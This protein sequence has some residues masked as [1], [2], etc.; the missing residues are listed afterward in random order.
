M[1]T[2]AGW[3]TL[4]TGLDT[5]ARGV[6]RAAPAERP[7]LQQRRHDHLPGRAGRQQPGGDCRP[8]RSRTMGRATSTRS[9]PADQHCPAQPPTWPWADGTPIVSPCALADGHEPNNDAGSATPLTVVTTTVTTYARAVQQQRGPA[10]RLGLL[11]RSPWP[12]S[13]VLSVTLSELPAD[14]RG[15]RAQRRR[16]STWPSATTT[17]WPTRWFRSPTPAAQR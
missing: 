2:A 9:L 6:A 10:Q 4:I 14:Y 1:R 12:A 7:L 15:D 5:D 11:S 8:L 3:P 16:L 17:A 13:K